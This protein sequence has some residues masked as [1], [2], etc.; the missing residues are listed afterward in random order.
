VQKQ[1][2][3]ARGGIPHAGVVVFADED[4]PDLAALRRFLATVRAR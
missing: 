3:P 1:L 4:D 2:D